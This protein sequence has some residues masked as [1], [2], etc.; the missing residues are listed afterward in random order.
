MLSW[1]QGQLVTVPSGAWQGQAHQPGA[2][3]I[4]E[5]NTSS[6][7]AM[8]YC[9]IYVRP[10]ACSQHRLLQ[11]VESRGKAAGGNSDASNPAQDSQQEVV[12][13]TKDFWRVSANNSVHSSSDSAG[14][15]L[16]YSSAAGQ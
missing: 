4:L 3:D 14:P 11:D 12:Y 2:G 9:S 1:A 8:L 5:R 7:K 15:T 10:V 6:P 16:Q 13:L